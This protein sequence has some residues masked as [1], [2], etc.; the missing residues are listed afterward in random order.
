MIVYAESSAVLSWLLAEPRGAAV[1]EVLG[2]ADHIVTSILT[3]MECARA[4]IRGASLG[5]ISRG[6]AT[7]LLR[8]WRDCREGWNLVEIGTRVAER[9]SAPFPLEPIR[10][11]DAIHVASAVLVRDEVGEVAMLSFDERVRSNAAA[12]GMP[13]LPA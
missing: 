7:A 3:D 8:Q 13:L 12:L 6:Q 11:L 9:A 5:A 4:L 1:E 10:T 2:A